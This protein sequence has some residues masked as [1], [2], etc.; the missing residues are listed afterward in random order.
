[1]WGA[2]R[3]GYASGD[4]VSIAESTS[5]GG[6]TGC[7][8]TSATVT[9]VNGHAASSPLT[10]GGYALTLQTGANTVEVTNVVTCVQSLALG[11]Q[12]SFGHALPS[13]WT[14]T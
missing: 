3:A 10:P 12:V 4:A 13:A 6:R 14:L 7:T 2:V 1:P 11:K 9:R 5:F 8:L